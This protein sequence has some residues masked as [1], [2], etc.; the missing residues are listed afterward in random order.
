MIGLVNLCAAYLW[1]SHAHAL[2]AETGL[3]FGMTDKLYSSSVVLTS[4]FLRRVGGQIRQDVLG[5]PSV[6]LLA[7]GLVLVLRRGKRFESFAMAGFVAYVFLLA[8]GCMVHDY[9]LLAVVPIASVLVPVGLCAVAGRIGRGDTDRELVAASALTTLL[10]VYSLF[11]TIGPHSWYDTPIDKVPLCRAGGT[12][13]AQ[14]DRLTFVGYA[15]PD[16]RYCLD[17]RGWLFEVG[18][19][20]VERLRA[21]WLQG[22]TVFVLPRTLAPD[23]GVE[24]LRERGTIAFANDGFEVVRL[25]P[26]SKRHPEAGQG[27][28]G[29]E[30]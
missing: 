24:W 13:P 16:L 12:F 30:P 28:G 4:F 5:L 15:N 8:Q 20:D 18:A 6:L 22:G 27:Q 19:A 1:Y 26:P 29:R 14:D 25:P 2:G 17:R 3:T 9:Y 10:L 7:L 21:V 23:R 11:R